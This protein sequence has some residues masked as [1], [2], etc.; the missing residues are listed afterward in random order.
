M[1][2][3][4]LSLMLKETQKRKK[5]R[6]SLDGIGI[7]K[8]PLWAELESCQMKESHGTKLGRLRQNTVAKSAKMRSKAYPLVI[9]HSY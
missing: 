3:N 1:D 2:T 9:S 7:Y 6:E 8:K 5:K 4:W